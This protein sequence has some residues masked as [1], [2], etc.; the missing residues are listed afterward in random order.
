MA[1]ILALIAIDE[2][3]VTRAALE[4]HIGRIKDTGVAIDLESPGSCLP[5]TVVG[6]V[7]DQ[8]EPLM[9]FFTGEAG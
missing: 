6:V 3:G 2:P 4:D 7:K 9:A 1:R 5:A 8:H